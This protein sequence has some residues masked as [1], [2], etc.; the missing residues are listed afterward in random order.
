MTLLI[1]T[2]DGSFSECPPPVPASQM[3]RLVSFVPLESPYF[4]PIDLEILNFKPRRQ[5]FKLKN[6]AFL[7]WEDARVRAHLNCFLDSVSAI[8]GLWSCI[9]QG[10]P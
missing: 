1:A 6:C 3:L 8:W 4:I 7:V 2:S 5:H 9:P 10:S